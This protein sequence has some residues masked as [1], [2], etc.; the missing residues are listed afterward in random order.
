LFSYGF[1]YLDKEEHAMVYIGMDIHQLS[2]TFCVFDPSADKARQ[3][4]TLTRPTTPET[5]EAVLGPHKR[6]CR[7]AFEVGTQAQWIA[8]IVRPLAAEVQV[9]NPS[10][11]PWLFRDGRKNDSLDAR[12]LATLLYLKQL[13]TVHL[14][15]ADISA[16]RALINHRRTLIK[17]RTRSKNQIHA[18]R[19][20]FGYRC[21]HRSC[22][23]RV[24]RV[25]LR[26]LT[27]DAAR[28]LMI[29][30]LLDELAFI[31]ER[32]TD[33]ERQLDGV[34]AT[35]PNVEL[36][37]TIPGIGPR[38]AEAIVAFA[39]I[40]D[41][42]PDRKRFASY[43][44]MTPTE[45]SSGLVQRHGHISKRG[46][47][48]VRWLLTEAAHRVVARCPVLRAFFARVYRGKRD[49]YKRAIIATGRKVLAICYGMMRD[50]TPFDAAKVM[51][52]AA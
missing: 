27:F 32:I 20:A 29:D 24:G 5:F 51:R 6:R 21:P 15:A 39:D 44:G 50:Q 19:R 42:F 26:S 1:G 9:A 14:P 33:V 12:K 25:W 35:Q 34:A 22:W 4:R 36:L 47:S 46:P 10:R 43:F 7:V 28:K 52:S 23:T 16:W 38:T 8:R 17:R 30:G 18:I 45:D 31:E 37:R 48:V 40:V 3:Y 13:P 41:R 2:T 11:I 49:R